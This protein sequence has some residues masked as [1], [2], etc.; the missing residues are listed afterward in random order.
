MQ[1]STVSLYQ[2]N[3]KT[4]QTN[5]K[6]L[7]VNNIT[8]NTTLYLH[9]SGMQMLLWFALFKKDHWKIFSGMPAKPTT[10]TLPS[11]KKKHVGGKIYWI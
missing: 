2:V 6:Y 10:I 9:E 1:W 11:L 7:R 4:N 8:L 5:R 3:V